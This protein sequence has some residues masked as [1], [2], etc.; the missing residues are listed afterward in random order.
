M[1]YDLIKLK[2]EYLVIFIIFFFV[3]VMNTDI[4]INADWSLSNYPSK[5]LK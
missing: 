3:P 5:Y 2:K 1:F 4:F